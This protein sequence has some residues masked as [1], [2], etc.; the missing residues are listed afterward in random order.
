M[1]EVVHFPNGF[2]KTREERDTML[3]Y[4]LGKVFQK[5][6]KEEIGLEEVLK[7]QEIGIT[8]EELRTIEAKRKKYAPA[9]NKI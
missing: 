1:D 6:S 3:R 9:K 7:A 4:F 5:K 2:T 8:V